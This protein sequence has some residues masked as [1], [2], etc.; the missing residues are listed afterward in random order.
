MSKTKANPQRNH[1]ITDIIYVTAEYFGCAPSE[2]LSL[3]HMRTVTL[4]RSVAYALARE[5][6]K[7]SL[8]EIGLAFARDHTTVRAQIIRLAERATKDEFLAR[9]LAICRAK[10]LEM[11]RARRAGIS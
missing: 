6:T 3:S 11:I 2:I 8:P 10:A 4:A 9:S 1:V 5:L 7:A